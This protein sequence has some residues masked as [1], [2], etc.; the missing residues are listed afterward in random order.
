[1]P[2]DLCL[3]CTAGG[4]CQRLTTRLVTVA[5]LRNPEFVRDLRNHAASFGLTID[6]W[7]PA[8][9]NALIRYP[10][11]FV[12]R[13]GHDVYLDMRVFRKCD[14][15]YWFREFCKPVSPRVSPRVREEALGRVIVLGSILKAYFPVKAALWGVRPANMDTEARVIASV[16][17]AS[18]AACPLHGTLL[19]P[20]RAVKKLFS[21]S[22]SP[23]NDNG[24]RELDEA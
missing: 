17:P 8:L 11:V 5:E 23:A 6:G 9:E 24:A 3:S 10:G 7:Y 19:M 18:P 4:A 21:R 15:R 2:L 1:M 20:G 12:S 16:W 14:Y 22:G 13:S